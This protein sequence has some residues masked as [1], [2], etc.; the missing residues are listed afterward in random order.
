VKGEGQSEGKGEGKGEGQSGVKGEGEASG[1]AR[2]R[3]RARV[4]GSGARCDVIW[5]RHLHGTRVELE[6]VLAPDPLSDHLE[7]QLAHPAE[8]LLPSSRVE[9]HH[10]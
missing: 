7:M 2:A 1:R 3:M 8:Q 10:E 5:T 9:P 6:L 4:E